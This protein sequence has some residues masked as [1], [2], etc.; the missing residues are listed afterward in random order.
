MMQLFMVPYIDELEVSHEQYQQE[1]YLSKILISS[2]FGL[3]LNLDIDFSQMINLSSN[4]QDPSPQ[5]RL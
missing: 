4:A 3:K 2:T 1:H 5:S